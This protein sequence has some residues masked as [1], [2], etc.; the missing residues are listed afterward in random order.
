MQEHAKCALFCKCLFLR[1]S[2]HWACRYGVVSEHHH[3]PSPI[4]G[5][6]PHEHV[7]GHRRESCGTGAPWLGSEVE[8]LCLCNKCV[9]LI[10]WIS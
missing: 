2:T 9:E 7:I 8:K 6:G 10:I 4:K 5:R 3:H 1:I